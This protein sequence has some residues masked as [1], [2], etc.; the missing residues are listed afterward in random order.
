[1]VWGLV[2]AAREPVSSNRRD[3]W[4]GDT[5]AYGIPSAVGM[6]RTSQA[7]PHVKTHR[8]M[9]SVMVAVCARHGDCVSAGCGCLTSYLY[10]P[11]D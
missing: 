3:G 5:C 7:Q 6:K 10:S 11:L 1:M 2:V 4:E 9:H 8:R